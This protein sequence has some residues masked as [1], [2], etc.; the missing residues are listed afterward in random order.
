MKTTIIQ[1]AKVIVLALVLSAGIALAQ[2]WTGPTSTPPQ[3]N[4]AAPINVG[5]VSQVKSGA[6]GT[7]PLA[8][9]G[10]SALYGNVSILGCTSSA[11]TNPNQNQPSGPSNEVGFFDQFNF[12]G[13]PKTAFARITLNNPP[14]NP[15]PEVCTDGIDNDLDGLIDSA[16]PDCSINPP[17]PSGGGPVLSPTSPSSPQPTSNLF[18]SGGVTVGALASSAAQAQ[19][20]VTNAG[21]LVLCTTTP[22]NPPT[23]PSGT[24]SFSTP[25]TYTFQ[26]PAG[27]TAITLEAWGG[28]GGGGGGGGSHLNNTTAGGGGGG[29]SGGY[30]K[31]VALAVTPLESFTVT[32]ASGGNG[33]NGGTTAPGIGAP[34]SNGVNGGTTTITRNTSGSQILIATGGQ[35]GTGGDGSSANPL[36]F[37]TGGPGGTGNS[38]GANGTAGTLASNAGGKGGNAPSGGTGG[39]GGVAGNNGQGGEGS[40]GSTPGAGGG[41]GG[42]GNGSLSSN[43]SGGTGGKGGNGRATFTW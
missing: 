26:V 2:T 8:V 20:C 43:F 18:V 22:T 28:G 17:P 11:C 14:F 29:G 25:G 5:T 3:G 36:F 42:G 27:V 39:T 35:R 13:L 38:A 6:L 12:F 33:G 16:D 32:V 4:V 34:G 15:S 21:Q 41:G 7:G 23:Q 37:G 19:V 24:Q 9:F 10:N 31:T 1:T 40:V 30:S